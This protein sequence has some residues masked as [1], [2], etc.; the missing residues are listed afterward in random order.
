MFICCI[1][2]REQCLPLLLCTCPFRPM[3]VW[4]NFTRHKHSLT[5]ICLTSKVHCLARSSR[6]AT[7]M[8]LSQNTA[9]PGS[10]KLLPHI[11]FIT[12]NPCPS[13]QTHPSLLFVCFCMCACCSYTFQCLPT[14]S[15]SHPHSEVIPLWQCHAQLASGLCQQLVWVSDDVTSNKWLQYQQVLLQS[16]GTCQ[17]LPN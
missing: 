11:D 14:H 3:A 7:V 10:S 16:D 15:S 4:W 12:Y 6:F 8:S 17:I 9:F 5:A 13:F 2:T 1:S